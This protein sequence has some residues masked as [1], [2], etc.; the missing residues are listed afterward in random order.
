MSVRVT[1]GVPFN[2]T[3]N[4]QPNLTA[5]DNT[6]IGTYEQMC[7]EFDK[8]ITWDKREWETYGGSKISEWATYSMFDSGDYDKDG[9]WHVTYP[10][11]SVNPLIFE[12]ELK[13][14]ISDWEAAETKLTNPHFYD[15]LNFFANNHDGHHGYLE[16]V[17]WNKKT[18]TL[19]LHSGS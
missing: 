1:H 5:F 4:K 6:V 9:D 8:L 16:G 14:K 7:D 17:N 3:M 15:I 13:V 18:K 2:N 11:F 19:E 10:D 12:G